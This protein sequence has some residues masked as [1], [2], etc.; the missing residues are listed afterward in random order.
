MN[1]KERHNMAAMRPKAHVIT[2]VH[3]GV[4]YELEADKGFNVEYDIYTGTKLVVTSSQRI[5]RKQTETSSITVEVE[6]DGKRYA[7]TLEERAV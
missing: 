7:G 4:T 5:R 3:D 1:E 6:I 2:F